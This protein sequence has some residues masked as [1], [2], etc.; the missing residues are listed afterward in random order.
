M[1]LMRIQKIQATSHRSWNAAYENQQEGNFTV[2][3]KIGLRMAKCTI[4]V[5]QGR[6]RITEQHQGVHRDPLGRTTLLEV[7]TGTERIQPK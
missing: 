6:S 2:R 7:Q 1:N 5:D 4:P 3:E